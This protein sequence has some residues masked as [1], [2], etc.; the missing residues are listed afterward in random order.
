MVENG[1]KQ[2]SNNR[3]RLR[4]GLACGV[5]HVLPFRIILNFCKEN[6]EIEVNWCEYSNQEVKKMIDSCEIEYGF[7]VG[8]CENQE[9]L[10]RKLASR[11]VCLLVYEGHPLFNRRVVSVNDLKEEPVL[12]MNEHF[13]MY[14]DF[15]EACQ[16]RGFTPDVVA[17]TADGSILHKLC[18]QKIGLAI[19]PDFVL[20]D[21]VMDHLRAIPLEE[22]LTWD[23]YG[24]YEK[25]N[26]SYETIKKFENYLKQHFE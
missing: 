12:V 5:F 10:Q 15:M 17:K 1:I 25:K 22:T 19:I 4:I 9:V 14:H 16:V 13:N 23:V 3:I 6:P 26:R 18:M 24:V 2:L 20:D 21:L 11:K 8:G 7:V